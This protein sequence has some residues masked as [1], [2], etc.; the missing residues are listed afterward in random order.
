M[1]RLAIL[2]ISVFLGSLATH[3]DA[4]ADD[5]VLASTSQR[6]ALVI[7]NGTYR[8]ERDRLINPANDARAIAAKLRELNFDVL[9]ALDLDRRGMQTSLR[10]FERMLS[11]DLEAA[12]FFY[13]G[14]GMEYDGQNY[15]FPIDA[16]LES[17]SDISVGLIRISQVLD[18]MERSDVATRLIFLDACR[19]NPLAGRFR[20]SFGATRSPPIG[21]GLAIIDAT[22]DA[23]LGTFVAYATAPGAVAEDGDGA[24]S[25]F[26]AALLQHLGKPGLDAHELMQGVTNSVFETTDEG[27][28]PWFSSSLRGPFVFNRGTSA[29]GEP[30]V[31][32][33]SEEIEE[34]SP[35]ETEADAEAFEQELTLSDK[36]KVQEALSSLGYKVGDVFVNEFRSHTR[37]AIADWQSDMDLPRKGWLSRSQFRRL[38]EEANLWDEHGWDDSDD[39]RSRP[40]PGSE[41]K[42]VDSDDPNGNDLQ[43]PSRQARPE[44]I[45]ASLALTKRQRV[46]MQFS[47][48]RLGHYKGAGL[49]GILG[50]RSREAIRTWQR[51]TGREGSGYLNEL[52]VASLYMAALPDL[53]EFR[54][55]Y[56]R[57]IARPA[58]STFRDCNSCPDMVVISAGRFR[59]GSSGIASERPIRRVSIAKFALGRFEVTSEEW[60]ACVRDGSCRNTGSPDSRRPVVD[61]SWHDARDYVDWLGGVTGERYYLP[62]EAEWE[63]AARAGT[64]TV[65]AMGD[66]I[67]ISQANFDGSRNSPE[68][69]NRFRGRAL[70]GGTFP[71]NAFGLYD[72]HGNVRE[73]VQ[74]RWHDDYRGAPRDGAA[75]LAGNAGER[76]QRG[77]SWRDDPRMLRSAARAKADPGSGNAYTG[78]RV[79]R[80]IGN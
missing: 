58:G 63:Y 71:A 80:K 18:I 26:T 1:F 65:F 59:M 30:K 20:R 69:A 41:D 50:L 72:M 52:Q 21:R 9:E 3:G 62:S 53:R 2:V 37:N 77:G 67:S 73:W 46:E 6:V 64:Q 22:V 78:F 33:L 8:N 29:E 36:Y 13:A 14:H 56:R 42:K 57:D 44:E 10:Q 11:P 49:D 4:A 74:D 25:P 7:G 61:V 51:R 48:S 47:L 15:L 12:L 60:S 23:G 24:H 66:R 68:L 45:E 17:E 79:A 27:Q 75:W 34:A 35:S 32:D 54:E 38:L 31:A 76:V 55:Q 39:D 43:G 16:E 28:I 19:N 40:D 70:V 5:G